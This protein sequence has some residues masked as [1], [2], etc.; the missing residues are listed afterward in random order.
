VDLHDAYDRKERGGL[1]TRDPRPIAEPA[2]EAAGSALVDSA[3]FTD[4]SKRGRFLASP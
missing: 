2:E 3:E 4:A 1:P